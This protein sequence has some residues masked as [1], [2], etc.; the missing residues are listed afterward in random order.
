[1]KKPYEKKKV[2]LHLASNDDT[3]GHS[4]SFTK[5]SLLERKLI[6]EQLYG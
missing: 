6:I 3:D 2:K 4:E 5:C 1:M